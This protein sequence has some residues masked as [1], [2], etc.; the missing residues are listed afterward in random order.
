MSRPASDTEF[1]CLP[2]R[3]EPSPRGHGSGREQRRL[4]ADELENEVQGV[5]F[6]MNRAFGVQ[7][8]TDLQGRDVGGWKAPCF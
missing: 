1:V 3:A 5:S 6:C 7:D 2:G 4:K 8:Q